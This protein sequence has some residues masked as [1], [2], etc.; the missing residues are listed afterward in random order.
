MC[1]SFLGYY[2][3]CFVDRVFGFICIL[4]RL[5][6]I[7]GSGCILTWVG[8]HILIPQLVPWAWWNVGVLFRKGPNYYF[9]SWL[10]CLELIFDFL[11]RVVRG[12]SQFLLHGWF[13][14]SC[15]L[16]GVWGDT[17]VGVRVVVT[18]H[19]WWWTRGV[20]L[21]IPLSR[22]LLNLGGWNCGLLRRSWIQIIGDC[23]V[24]NVQVTY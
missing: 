11:P 13:Q 4:G 2:V 5:L 15:R 24:E 23:F 8:F 1:H 12:G 10:S 22:I 6:H 17:Q 7:W 21:W 9:P 20:G 16:D 18:N 19:S 3:S 14:I